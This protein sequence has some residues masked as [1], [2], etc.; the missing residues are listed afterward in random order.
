VAN[1]PE[2]ARRQASTTSP[3]DVGIHPQA[4]SRPNW[5]DKGLPFFDNQGR[6]TLC[7]VLGGLKTLRRRFPSK[8]GDCKTAK[9][10]Y[11]T[12]LTLRTLDTS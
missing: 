8:P 12:T 1:V 5:H 9:A 7:A 4:R 6:T 11:V 2:N 10:L 3:E